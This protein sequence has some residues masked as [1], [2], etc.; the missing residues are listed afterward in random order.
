[1]KVIVDIHKKQERRFLL[2][3]PELF[4]GESGEGVFVSFLHRKG[5]LV[6]HPVV[7]L[8]S[9]GMQDMSCII[10]FLNSLGRV[11]GVIYHPMPF[12]PHV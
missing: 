12:A 11:F 5:R 4:D 2:G 7:N 8:L 1:M 3:H 9:T 6:N 10:V